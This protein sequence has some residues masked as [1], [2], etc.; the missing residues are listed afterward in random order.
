MSEKDMFWLEPKLVEAARL[1]E[2]FGNQSEQMEAAMH[3][4]DKALREI[5]ESKSIAKK[6]FDSLDS[7][8]KRFD[9]SFGALENAFNEQSFATLC[10]RI[11]ELAKVLDECKEVRDELA[12]IKANIVDEVRASVEEEMVAM[13]TELEESR[14]MIKTL[15]EEQAKSLSLIE[16]LGE[17]QRASRALIEAKLSEMIALLS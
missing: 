12:E 8:C 15:S 17:E 1:A 9:D 4:L 6:A 7:L 5:N 16:T 11:A 2:K 10:E 13:R 14:A 3:A